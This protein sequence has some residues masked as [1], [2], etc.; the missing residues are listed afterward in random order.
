[1][2]TRYIS[3]I[4]LSELDKVMSQKGLYRNMTMRQ[5]VRQPSKL[6]AVYVA[7]SRI[8]YPVTKEQRRIFDAFKVA[9]PM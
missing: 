6:R 3:L 9:P 5:M 1:M 8:V 2:S 7:G 4:L